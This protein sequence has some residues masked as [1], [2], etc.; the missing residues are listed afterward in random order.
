M[1]GVGG[2]LRN[3]SHRRV[4]SILLIWGKGTGGLAAA[5]VL[6]VSEIIWRHA[7]HIAHA[8]VRIRAI[9]SNLSR[10][11]LDT[12]PGLVP[13]EARLSSVGKEAAG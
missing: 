8:L 10:A 3:A 4:I 7:H 9:L 12:D 2:A 6:R 1:L 5:L 11:H 13:L